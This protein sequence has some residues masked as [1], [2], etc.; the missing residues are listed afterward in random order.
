ML[1]STPKAGSRPPKKLPRLP[2]SPS[3]NTTKSASK[4][5]RSSV[6]N[7]KKVSVGV[8]FGKVVSLYALLIHFMLHP[9]I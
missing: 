8:L 2:P 5:R 4:K 3:I 9:F 7:P 1:T 6:Y